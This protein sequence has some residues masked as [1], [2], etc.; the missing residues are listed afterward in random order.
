ML[1]DKIKDNKRKKAS[2][3]LLDRP[4]FHIYIHYNMGKENSTIL[5]SYSVIDKISCGK[6]I[7]ACCTPR[8]GTKIP[9]V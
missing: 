9:V 5:I 3:W 2:I 1:T 6:F 8:S 4:V 7:M